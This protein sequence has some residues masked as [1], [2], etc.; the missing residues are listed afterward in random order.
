MSGKDGMYGQV[1]NY[2]A[3][4]SDK[5]AILIEAILMS[6]LNISLFYRRSKET[7]L[8]VPICILTWRFD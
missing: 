2:E 8:T 5:M 3:L 1:L 4:A 7:S 6:T